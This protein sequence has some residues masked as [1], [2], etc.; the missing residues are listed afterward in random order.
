MS[1]HAGEPHNKHGLVQPHRRLRVERSPHGHPLAPP[2]GPRRR[3]VG[4]PPSLATLHPHAERRRLLDRRRVE[5]SPPRLA[6]RR[7]PFVPR[8]PH[9][10]GRRRKPLAGR[11]SSRPREAQR[12]RRQRHHADRPSRPPTRGGASRPGTAHPRA[13]RTQRHGATPEQPPAR[14]FRHR[15]A[16]LQQPAQR[17]KAVIHPRPL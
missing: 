2:A 14:P 9:P 15:A 6:D 1:L 5:P 16:A 7:P 8:R 11:L 17:R 10:A 4:P 3:H 13:R 12:P